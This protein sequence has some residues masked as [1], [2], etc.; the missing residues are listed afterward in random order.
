MHTEQCSNLG[1]ALHKHYSTTYGIN[2]DS[3]VNKSRYFH[4][5]E[6]LVPDVMHDVLEGAL[7]LEVKQLLKLF[8]G[9]KSISLSML[10]DAIQ[11]FP[12]MGADAS[13]KPSLISAQTLASQDNLLKQS[14][15][16]TIQYSKYMCICVY[17]PED[18]IC[19]CVLGAGLGVVLLIET[20]RRGRGFKSIYMY[21][22]SRFSTLLSCIPYKLLYMYT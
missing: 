18:I 19:T 3:I 17:Q 20:R 16:C 4:V 13:N 1:G 5:T 12:Y 2:C 11:A 14:G 10:N 9:R 6:G 22:Y 15:K 8:I 7:E 21:T